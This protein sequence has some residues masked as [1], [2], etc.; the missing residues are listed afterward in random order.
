LVMESLANN[1]KFG[2]GF[3]D[4][5]SL[6]ALRKRA[7]ETELPGRIRVCNEIGGVAEKH[8]EL[9]NRHA[10]FQVASHFNCLEL[11]DPS[12]TPQDGV[13]GYVNDRTQGPACSLACGAATVFRNYFVRV[14]TTTGLQEG[15]TQDNMI[16]NLSQVGQLVGNV[17]EGRLF[18]VSGGYTMA[19]QEQLEELDRRLHTF[20]QRGLLDSVRSALCVGVQ[21]DA[22]V[23]ATDW[24]RTIF[25]DPAQ[26]VTQVLCSA[27]AVAY[28]TSTQ[29]ES[30]HRFASIVLEAAYEAVLYVALLSAV[31]YR[32]KHGSRR[33]FL[34]CLG[35][36][37]LGN[38]LPWVVAAMRRALEKFRA[39]NLD[40]RIVTYA[41]DVPP[42][43][44]A[45]ER[46]FS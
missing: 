34:T 32:G 19:S 10:T 1:K 26:T 6:G 27:C 3:F 4:T 2:V 39:C 25:D 41:G 43:L 18:K 20:E 21:Y 30:W 33:V 23:T 12:A 35:G 22:Q 46:D 15:Q 31:R 17:P 40:V 7:A 29:P 14:R 44:L 16:N 28:N 38:P 13:T 5:P 11:V 45:L 24:G 37:V 9:E 36:G 8:A 42:Q